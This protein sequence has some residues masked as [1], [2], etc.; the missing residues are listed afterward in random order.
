V[1]KKHVYWL[2]GWKDVSEVAF[3]DSWEPNRNINAPKLVAQYKTDHPD[4][5]DEKHPEA[6]KELEELAA[7]AAEV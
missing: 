7:A 4:W 1:Y 2:C 6:M 3:P 5:K